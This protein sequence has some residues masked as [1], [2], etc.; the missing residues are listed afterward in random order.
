MG[1]TIKKSG[2]RALL[3]CTVV[4]AVPVPLLPLELPGEL[5]FFYRHGRLSHLYSVWSGHLARRLSFPALLERH[6]FDLL[7]RFTVTL[8]VVGFNYRIEQ[9]PAARGVLFSLG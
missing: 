8:R 4:Q 9:L 2:G 7:R 5:T 6:L 1:V 3:R